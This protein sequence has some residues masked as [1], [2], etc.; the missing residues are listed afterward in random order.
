MQL[1]QTIRR[2]RRHA[3]L[4]PWDT[5]VSLNCPSGFVH[6]V[7]VDGRTF[8]LSFT[9]S[10]KS[11]GPTPAYVLTLSERGRQRPHK[12]AVNKL[13]ALFFDRTREVI[14][15][16]RFI[17]GYPLLGETHIY[18]QYRHQKAGRVRTEVEPE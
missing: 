11:Y 17:G 2:I 7:E 16:R 1:E 12:D 5:S 9:C 13:L 4:N 14:R 10:V 8:I 18:Y 6:R 3:A 15:T